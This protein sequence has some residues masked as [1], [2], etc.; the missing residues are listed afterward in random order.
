[1]NIQKIIEDLAASG[2]SQKKIA[3]M[4]KDRGVACTQPRIH[5]A[6]HGAD[7]GYEVGRVLVELHHDLF[8]SDAA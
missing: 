8:P 2:L 5:R 1:M 7:P 3:E 6:L 4:V